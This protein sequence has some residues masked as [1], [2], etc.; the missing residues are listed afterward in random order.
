MSVEMAMWRMSDGGPV[1]LSTSMLDAEARL[2]QLVIRDPALVGLDVLVL[3]SQVKT[4]HGGFIDVLAMD[5]D[6][7]V[8]VL[9]LKRDKTPR[10]VVAQ[11]LDYGSWVDSL[12]VAELEAV[13]SQHNEGRSLPAVFADRFGQP[14]PDTVNDTH[15]M[16]IVASALDPAS[17]RIVEYLAGRHGVPINA[18]FFSYFADQDREYLGRTW[19]LDPVDVATVGTVSASSKKKR[20]WNGRDFYTVQ[21]T[22]QEVER[23]EL[24]RRYGLISGGG[25][26]RYWKPMRTLQPG[27]RVF[28]YVAGAG[29][30]GVGEVTGT[31][32]PGS[33]AMATD[34]DT[35]K[36][37]PL[38]TRPDLHPN[39][40]KRLESD[41]P[42]TTEYVVSVRWI[43]TR[44]VSEAVKEENLFANQNTVCKLRDPYT[45]AHLTNAFGLK[46]D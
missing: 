25:G 5:V 43:Q 40:A 34:P 19:L 17:D 28:A 44:D 13:F 37:V 45:L 14:L 16:T 7:A 6:G 38:A 18:V 2:E 26:K 30:V 9:E 29:Y 15:Q 4:A 21:G 36:P 46:D 10:D 22:S 33:Q 24:A 31:V 12:G 35:G 23:W 3:G 41:D 27:H 39:F 32:Q 11:A 42:D 1:S 20:P 8:H